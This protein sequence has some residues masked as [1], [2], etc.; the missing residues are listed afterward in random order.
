MQNGSFHMPLLLTSGILS[1]VPGAVVALHGVVE[2]P[3]Q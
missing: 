2:E 3:G 1:F